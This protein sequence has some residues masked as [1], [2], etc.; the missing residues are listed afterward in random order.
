VARYRP[1]WHVKGV[2]AAGVLAEVVAYALVLSKVMGNWYF[3]LATALISIATP[4]A[5]RAA[6]PEEFH[7]DVTVAPG[8]QDPP[9]VVQPSLRA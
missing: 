6:R 3:V 4:V 2:L 8:S 5:G 7:R 1:L 9:L